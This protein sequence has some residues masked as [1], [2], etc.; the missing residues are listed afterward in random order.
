[1]SSYVVHQSN[2]GQVSTKRQLQFDGV[3]DETLETPKNPI[4][5]QRS[6]G[7]AFHDVQ[8][9]LNRADTSET[10]SGTPESHDTEKASTPSSEEKGDKGKVRTAAEKVVHNRKMRFFRSLDSGKPSN[11]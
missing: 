6:E 10:L 9:A 8:D 4:S 3:V 11:I 1:M 7:S 5:K 2:F